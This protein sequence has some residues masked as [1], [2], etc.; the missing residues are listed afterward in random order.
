MA[1]KPKN[2]DSEMSEDEAAL[3]AVEDAL[4][5]D[6]DEALDSETNAEASHDPDD[7]ASEA[8]FI[9]GITAGD[10]PD[11]DD[12][13]IDMDELEQKLA[14]VA[15]DLRDEDEQ[16][17]GSKDDQTTTVDDSE[18]ELSD[19]IDASLGDALAKEIEFEIETDENTT[20]LPL[21]VKPG[22]D[23]QTPVVAA[24]LSDDNAID[25]H[26][27]PA[28]DRRTT[29]SSEISAEL[30][31]ATSTA[32]AAND[33]RENTISDLVYALQK[34]PGSSVGWVSAVV[35]LVWASGC[36]FFGFSRFGAEISAVSSIGDLFA[37]PQIYLMIAVIILPLLT[38][39]AFSSMVRR[40]QEMR[41][42][43]HSMTEAAIR[44]LQPEG[45]ASESFNTL[46]HAIRREVAA[47]GD[48]V[49]RALARAS[50]LENMVQSEVISLERSYTDS[51]IKLRG[52][53]SELSGERETIENHAEKMRLSI[54]GTHQG[55]SEEITGAT[56]RIQDA[57]TQ[58]TNQ[59]SLTLEERRAN[60]SASLLE[61]G[62]NLVAKMSSASSDVQARLAAS[63]EALG[64]GIET[65]TD[66]LT[67]RIKLV[68]NAMATLLDTRSAQIS[69]QSENIARKF[70]ESVGQRSSEFAERIN[71][72]GKT[73]NSALDTRISTISST[74]S[75][76]GMTLVE[77]L[78]MRTET[79]DK[80]LSE[81]ANSINKSIDD[82]MGSLVT[83]LAEKTEA[84]D[85][86]MTDRTAAIGTTI[87][88]RLSGFGQT[89][90]GHVDTV[91]AQLSDKTA[92]LQ[93]T[94]ERVET[95][96]EE[97]TAS[98][99]ETL[100]SRTKELAETFGNS[101]IQI[102]SAI[103]EGHKL[104]TEG[105][106]QKIS[107]TA[108]G[109][110]DKAEKLSRL[111]GERAAAINESMGSNLVE[112]QRTLERFNENL[113]TRSEEF[114]AIVEDK[115]I[116]MVESM[117]QASE[118]V[119]SQLGETSKI[120]DVS[121]ADIIN[122]LGSSNKILG[123]LVDRA[124]ENLGTI[125]ASLA[126]QS[127]SL[128]KAFDK[129]T[130][131]LELS[132]KLAQDVQ[133]GMEKTASGLLADVNQVA[134]RLDEQGNI[135]VEAT[136]LIDASQTNFATTL[137]SR[138]EM[139]KELSDGLVHRS[140][141]IE[142]T[143]SKLAMAVGQ[144]LEEANT[145]SRELGGIVS[146]EVSTAINDATARFSNATESMKIAARDVSA[147]LEQTR[148]QMRRGILELPDETRQSADSMRRVVTDQIKALKDLSE[149]V[150]RSGKALD[151]S[152][153]ARESRNR[154]NVVAAPAMQAAPALTQP[155]VQPAAPVMPPQR[156][157]SATP[158][159]QPA[160]QITPQAAPLVAPLSF[161]P[162]RQSNPPQAS[163]PAPAQRQKPSSSS[164]WVS[165][166][167]RRAS[168][169]EPVAPPAP[170]QQ[171]SGS[172]RS[173]KNVVESL[174]ALSMDIAR[175]IDHEA[176]VELWDRYQRGERNVFTRRLYTIQGQQ[177]FDEI[178]RKYQSEPEFRN[179]VTRYVEDFERLLA[180]IAR[181][182]RDN[183]MTQTYLTS[184]TGKVYTMLAHASG[185]FGS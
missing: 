185:R 67:D 15:N 182:D 141:E 81:K 104:V 178:Q 48:G 24:D 117:R 56:T 113:L 124:G 91:V 115:A 180:D 78:G 157:Q 137:D 102:A 25:Y 82:G 50:E 139:L 63:G 62:D 16:G 31:G 134:D 161:S 74:L 127:S 13:E 174:N 110:D 71:E 60:I 32:L 136:R 30:P 39:W 143:M 83:G 27:A 111:L 162:P 107:Q 23:A 120:V 46:G 28:Q 57:V 14:S 142:A 42:A 144:M 85:R 34:K 22:I 11:F 54:A 97:R 109:L 152:P 53:V 40:A 173:P 146:A 89:L 72:A 79:L 101:E 33:D 169:D 10:D 88:D 47:M 94:T 75:T 65:K 38:L 140:G 154:A 119:A 76:Q 167:L 69:E 6:L 9:A 125:Q 3:Q 175:A 36:I 122:K 17:S 35:A 5:L 123:T 116:P 61:A 181:N 114:S 49:E 73:I 145:R 43:A 7:K 20:D 68:G 2:K 59:I 1:L 126:Q 100:L 70:E 18:F 51:E 135:L 108:A 99:N 150:N 96:I 86:V 160:P 55:L 159:S 19:E 131:D 8:E 106:D 130:T 148:E 64:V 168:N 77:A 92:E 118:E 164:G 105:L 183:V 171:A 98:M 176:S 26:T 41:H 133:I 179:A 21:D 95:A 156:P 147:E 170:P 87:A 29:Q 58:A 121:V 166:L 155:V 153:A 151:A 90:T 66:E 45:I 52:L 165:D 4:N 93:S 128:M 103:A 163:R 177:T 138:Q 132:G 12:S 84:L 184:D 112:T 172:E 80:I 44:L 129:A 37:S 158:A 149:I